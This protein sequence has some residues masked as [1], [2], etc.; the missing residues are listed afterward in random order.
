MDAGSFDM[1][2]LCTG[3]LIGR[4]LVENS[5]NFGGHLM[6]VSTGIRTPKC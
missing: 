6:L 1:S 4:L 2:L 5:E 3:P